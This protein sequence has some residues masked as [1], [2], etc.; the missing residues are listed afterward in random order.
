MYSAVIVDDDR[1]IIRGLSSVVPWQKL[2]CRVVGTAV[3]GGEGIRLIRECRPDLLLTDIRMPNMDG[4]SMAAAVRSEFPRMQMTVLTAYRDFEY[5]RQAIRLG[6]CRYL[7]K[8][9]SMEELEEAVR[10]MVS[11][12]KALPPAEESLPETGPDREAHGYVVRNALAWMQAH[13]TEHLTLE[14]VASHV[15]V[16]QWHLSKLINRETGSGFLD[17][18]NRMRVDAAKSLLADP[19]RRIVD[20][21]YDAGFADVAHFSKTFKKLTGQTPGEYRAS[22]PQDPDPEN[23]KEGGEKT[24]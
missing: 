18:L 12:L 23:R 9:S 8:P 1:L 21:A 6:V 7:L 24:W 13:C 16:S 17:L 11:R 2:G 15:Y 4:L 22:R 19:G 5:A 20:A 3:D 14:D 10:E